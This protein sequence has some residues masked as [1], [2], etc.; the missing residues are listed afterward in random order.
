MSLGLDNKYST[1][2]RRLINHPR[3]TTLRDWIHSTNCL[4]VASQPLM[5]TQFAQLG[6]LDAL[7]DAGLMHKVTGMSGVSSGSFV[8][9]LAATHN[10]SENSRKFRQVWPGWTNI[11]PRGTEAN[12]PDLSENYR[13]RVLKHALPQ[14][15]E[16][17]KIP[18]GITATA[19]QD[20]KAAASV[21]GDR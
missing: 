19:Y 17:L 18:I 8:T 20:E 15:F 3:G 9:A 10:F 13:S 5:N 2:Y 12:D 7:N 11:V 1:V 14:S 16:E 6:A 4:N 21:D